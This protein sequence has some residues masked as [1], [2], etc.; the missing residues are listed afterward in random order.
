MSITIIYHQKCQ[1][2]LNILPMLKEVKNYEIDYIDLSV[3]KVEADINLDIVPMLIIDNKD[4]FKGKQ[5]FDKL[6]ELKMKPIGKMG[7][8]MYRPISIAPED[9]S[10]KK[11]PVDLGGK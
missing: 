10:N 5:A 11:N 1:A 3:D 9:D 2:S 4:I 6:E 7:K 8:K